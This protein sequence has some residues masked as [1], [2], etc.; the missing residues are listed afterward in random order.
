MDPEDL[1]II[2]GSVN[3]LSSSNGF[4]EN[5]RPF[6]YQE[7]IDLGNEAVRREEYRALG[8]VTEFTYSTQVKFQL[9]TSTDD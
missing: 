1:R 2:Y 7:V 8:T 3:S 4:I 9:K 6:V 5:S